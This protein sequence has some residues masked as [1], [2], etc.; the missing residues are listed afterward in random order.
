M[1]GGCPPRP[2]AQPLI[3]AQLNRPISG[4]QFQR[5]AAA[6]QLAPQAIVMF[7]ALAEGGE[8]RM[9]AAIAGVG[10][11]ISGEVLWQAQLNAAIA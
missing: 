2:P 1:Q 6:V 5:R 11:H 7:T 4:T 9:N 8:V 3:L 10:I